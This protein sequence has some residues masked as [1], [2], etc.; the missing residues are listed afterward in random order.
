MFRFIFLLIFLA[1]MSVPL[2]ARANDMPRFSATTLELCPETFAAHE[3]EWT[4]ECLINAVRAWNVKAIAELTAD[5]AAFACSANA[6]CHRDFVFGPT[7]WNGAEAEKRP[8]FYMISAAHVVT[9][10]YVEG[11]HGLEAVFYPGWSREARYPKPELN[12]ANWM[13]SF[14]VCAMA[15]E[16]SL[17]VW[18]IADGFCHSEMGSREDA[19]EERHVEPLPDARHAMRVPGEIPA[20]HVVRVGTAQS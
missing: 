1:A 7:P 16:P 4:A 11:E 18:L 12:S 6:P 14:F 15:F 19:P 3:P 13:N 5:P 17:G 9:V 10:E 20:A 8:L 2:L